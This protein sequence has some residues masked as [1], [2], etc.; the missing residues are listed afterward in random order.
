MIY[1]LCITKSNKSFLS[2]FTISILTTLSI[3][4]RDS[5]WHN[6]QILPY[7]CSDAK[8][9]EAMTGSSCEAR[10]GAH[11]AADTHHLQQPMVLLHQPLSPTILLTPPQLSHLLAAR[12][13]QS[14]A[15]L[16]HSSHFPYTTKFDSLH[17]HF[18][19]LTVTDLQCFH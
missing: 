12:Q 4:L 3:G 15:R 19:P 6:G 10:R 17:Q 16:P 5:A 8:L 14:P 9:P 2:H 13:P 7:V 18:W 11:H 1:G